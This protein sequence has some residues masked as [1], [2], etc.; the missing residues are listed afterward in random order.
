L[1]CSSIVGDVAGIGVGGG[2]IDGGSR[3]GDGVRNTTAEQAQ[4]MEYQRE[5]L[6]MV[7]LASRK[8]REIQ[9]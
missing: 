2:K 6:P 4:V 7:S 9:L 8:K 5:R 1:F 3:V